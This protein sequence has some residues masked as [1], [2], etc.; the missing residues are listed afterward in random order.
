M[1][2]QGVGTVVCDAGPIIHL[3][4]LDSLRLIGGFQ[5]VIVPD[6]V[7]EEVKLHRPGC[8]EKSGLKI[9]RETIQYA[10]R[11]ETAVLCR[12]LSLDAGE[13]AALGLMEKY[14]GAIFLSDDCAARLAA[15]RMGYAVHGTIGII[16][17]AIRME[18][19]SAEEVLRLL[20]ELPFRSSLHIRPSLLEEIISQVKKTVLTTPPD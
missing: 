11:E 17:R 6:P 16:V 15:E 9:I 1:I 8:L 4:E 10:L 7:H 13:T 19:M 2:E 3:G 12:L 20:R 18:L 14:P 5:Q